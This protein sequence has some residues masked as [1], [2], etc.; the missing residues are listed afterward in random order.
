MVRSLI[1]AVVVCVLTV[2]R[3]FAQDP[4]GAIEGV[5]TDKTAGAVAAAKVIVKNTD[6]GF[7][8]EA[9]SGP[10]GFYRVTALPVGTYSLTVEAPRFAAF[11]QSQI[12]VNVNQ[13][14]R[15]DVQLSVGDRRRVRHRR[16]TRTARRHVQQRAGRAW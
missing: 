14:V 13:A 15:V 10:D 2:S 3:A 7:G 4:T 8:R 12:P 16:R 9:V 11:S 6:T 1:G 5:V